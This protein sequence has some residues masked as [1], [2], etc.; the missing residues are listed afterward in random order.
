MI[1]ELR[2]ERQGAH[3]REPAPD[4][5]EVERGD[6]EAGDEAR[7]R[8]PAP[9]QYCGEDDRPADRDADVRGER[10]EQEPC[11]LLL[12]R[13]EQRPG[14]DGGLQRVAARGE[15]VDGGG[16]A[17]ERRGD[18]AG[19]EAVR[20]R[21]T[22]H[23]GH[24]TRPTI[25]ATAVV[26]LPAEEIYAFLSDLRN[27]WLLEDRFVALGGL[28]GG[29]HAPTGG[30]VLMKG[31]LGLSRRVRTRVLTAEAPS[32]DRPGLLQ[33]EA[34]AGTAT[35]GHVSWTIARDRSAS[36]VTLAASVE[37][38][39]AVDRLLLALVGRR[40]LRGV[41]RRTLSNL[42]RVLAAGAAGARGAAH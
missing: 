29:E 14:R 21:V 40:W 9:R 25:E 7:R 36:L 10:G 6:D 11:T 5:P 13:E 30:Q 15:R 19:G 41:F 28:D 8:R 34:R 24:H 33:G 37:R 16:D 1:G 22:A 31:P 38:A 35:V 3:T 42:E 26:P 18:G 12:A 17:A 39:S 4:D 20:D 23:A 32:A 2:E 27:H